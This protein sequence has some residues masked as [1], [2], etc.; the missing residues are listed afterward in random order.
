MGRK[1]K[2]EGGQSSSEGLQ[3]SSTAKDAA[4]HGGKSSDESPHSDSTK[5]TLVVFR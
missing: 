2:K 4:G 3:S 5:G 1:A